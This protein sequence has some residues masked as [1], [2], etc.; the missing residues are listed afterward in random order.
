LVTS[1]YMVVLGLGMGMLMQTTMLITQNSVSQRNLGAASG[2]TTLFQTVGGSLGVSLLG[3]LFAQHLTSSLSAIPGAAK[4]PQLSGSNQ[5]TPAML[6]K[7]PATVRTIFQQAIANGIHQ[8][9]LWGALIAVGAILAAL[10]V[11]EV[12]LR[13][14][15]PETGSDP[16]TTT[17]PGSANPGEAMVIRGWSMWQVSNG[18]YAAPAGN[19]SSPRVFAPTFVETFSKLDEATTKRLED[20]RRI[21]AP[22]APM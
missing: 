15:T 6:T 3:T 1:A 17:S 12:P 10:I 4:S 21:W 16:R 20:H 11:R 8:V 14:S 7:L 22:S 9:F 13:G 5:L 19:P 18:W 2:A